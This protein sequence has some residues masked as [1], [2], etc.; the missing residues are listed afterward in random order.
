MKLFIGGLLMVIGIII[1][2]YMPIIE[3]TMLVRFLLGVTW[4]C[5]FLTGFYLAS[6]QL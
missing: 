2:T 1:A 3:V 4:S 6:G 5:M